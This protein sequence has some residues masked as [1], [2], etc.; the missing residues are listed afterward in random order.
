LGEHEAVA[1]E[2]ARA[3]IQLAHAALKY[4]EDMAASG[5]LPEEL[6]DQF[7]MTYE[8]RIHRLDAA[9]DGQVEA[10]DAADAARRIPAL[11]RELIA[12]ERGRLTELLRRGEI[13]NETQ[14]RI[15]HELDLEESRLSR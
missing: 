1:R 4:I 15:E 14:R 8:Q 2:G 9:G 6:V 12:A 13:S 3:R 7:R 11:R 10:T 5:Q